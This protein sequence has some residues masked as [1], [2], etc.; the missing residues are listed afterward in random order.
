MQQQQW[1]KPL[2]SVNMLRGRH[3]QFCKISGSLRNMPYLREISFI[4]GSWDSSLY[5]DNGTDKDVQHSRD[6]IS[7]MDNSRIEERPVEDTCST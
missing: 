4:V 1:T 6:S 7:D 5:A 2:S 3:N